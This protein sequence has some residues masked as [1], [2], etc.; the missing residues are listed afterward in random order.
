[1]W[2]NV[3]R[4]K[5]VKRYGPTDEQTDRAGHR[6][7][8][9][10]L[11]S[12][13]AILVSPKK[14]GSVKT[15]VANHY[16]PH[17]STWC[18]QRVDTSAKRVYILLHPIAVRASPPW[19]SYKRTFII[20]SNCCKSIIDVNATIFINLTSSV[21]LFL[22]K[23]KVPARRLSRMFSKFLVN[24]KYKSKF[25]DS[26]SAWLAERLDFAIVLVMQ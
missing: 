20:T 7:A 2:N 23:L 14:L 5:I 21:F 19:W 25:F 12:Y 10:R 22:A 9:T 24:Q 17:W 8:F 4:R 16:V 18:F 26:F 13:W 3:K 11:K 15:R 6:V 1:M